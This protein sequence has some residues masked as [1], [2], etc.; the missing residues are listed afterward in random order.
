MLTRKAAGKGDLSADH[1]G[2][3]ELASVQRLETRAQPERCPRHIG[4]FRLIRSLMVHSIR[5]TSATSIT[6]LRP[7]LVAVKLLGLAVP[8]AMA[9]RPSPPRKDFERLAKA[10]SAEREANRLPEALVLYQKALKLNPRW[11]E[12][13]W[14]VGT[15][16]YEADHYPEALAAFRN[17]PGLNPK[18][19][20]PWAMLGLCEFET[21]DYKNALIHLERGRTLG[22]SGNEELVNVTRYH[23]ALLLNLQGQFEAAAELL[24]SLVNRGL[25]SETLKVALGISLLRVALLPKQIDPSKDALIH[26]AG[27]VARLV[28]LNNL[29]QADKAFRQLIEE[30][31]N[32]PFIH[33]A[34]GSML[35]RVS[36]YEE[37]E[38]EFKEEIVT[39]PES[40]LPYMQLAYIYLRMKRHTEA[41]SL[42][43]KAVEL[44]PQS[45]VAHYLLGRTMLEQGDVAR[46]I[47]SLEMARRLGPFSPE[48]RYNLAL[49]YARAQRKEEAQ[50]ERAEFER[51][52]ALLERRQQGNPQSY[53][54]LSERGNLERHVVEGAAE[55]PPK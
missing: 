27:E 26:A 17:L 48:V 37:A 46:A 24:D 20:P 5:S 10:A 34:Y 21:G 19:G 22:L 52:N 36:K 13:W 50:R 40:A 49:A 6:L 33:Y 16:H 12:G 38:R 45:F 35:T 8:L 25:S 9:Q 29:D 3:R 43:R 11:D 23:Q 14:Y 54:S 55:P 30:F 53:R 7:C 41:L 15:I 28:A 51:L 42:T 4:W 1:R 32:T 2:E 39:T 31:P 47:K 44:A 18:L